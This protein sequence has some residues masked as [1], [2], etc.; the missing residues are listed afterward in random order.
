MH[1]RIRQQNYLRRSG[2]RATPSPKQMPND[3]LRLRTVWEVLSALHERRARARDLLAIRERGRVQ[4]QEGWRLDRVVEAILSTRRQN[5]MQRNPA[6]LLLG[7]W[8]G[9]RT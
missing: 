7:G 8:I 1:R 6:L 5:T 2:S 4:V 3:L 9:Q